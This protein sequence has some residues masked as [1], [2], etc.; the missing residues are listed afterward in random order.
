[1]RH[2]LSYLSVMAAV[3]IM[4][5]I[6]G[7]GRTTATTPATIDFHVHVEDTAYNPLSGAKVVSEAQPAGQSKI[8]GLTDSG[9]DVT[10]NDVKTGDYTLYVSRFDYNQ[11]E[12]A[13]TI[14][15]ANNDLTVKMTLTTTTTPT[16]TN[17]PITVTFDQLIAQ[18]ET[19]NGT[20]VTLEGFY[21]S[22]FEISALASELAPAPYNPENV[23]PKQPLIWI[24]GN[25]GQDVYDNLSQ[26]TNTPSGYPE[27]FGKVQ[28]TGQFQYGGKYGHLDA[29]N[30]QLTVISAKLLPWS[31]ASTQS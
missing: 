8:T 27:H 28:I 13:I 2:K 3:L 29:Y 26:Q 18:P 10:F 15:P 30:Y 5:L 23:T 12:I 6:A 31:P 19:Y 17:S 11:V 4:Y 16:P 21:F 20:F 1:M 9:G 25:L 24:T 7:C 14:T 22:G